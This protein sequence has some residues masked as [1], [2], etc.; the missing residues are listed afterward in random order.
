[1]FEYRLVIVLIALVVVG[2]LALLDP[3]VAAAFNPILVRL[4]HMVGP[5]PVT[6]PRR[7]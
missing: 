3:A 6:T 7:E 2:A 5:N 1:M 4:H